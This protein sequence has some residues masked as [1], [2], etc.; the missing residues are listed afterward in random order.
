[1]KCCDGFFLFVLFLESEI[2][3]IKSFCVVGFVGDY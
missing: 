3:K 2:E 1:M